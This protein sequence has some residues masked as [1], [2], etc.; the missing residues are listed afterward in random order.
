VHYLVGHDTHAHDQ[1]TT[2]GCEGTIQT[3]VPTGHETGEIAGVFVAEYTDP[4]GLVGSDQ[5]VL[6][7]GG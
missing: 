7:P 1:S 5:V 3:T 2:A 4:G 6:E